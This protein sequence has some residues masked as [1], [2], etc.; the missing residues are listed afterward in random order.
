M[1]IGL[2]LLRLAEPFQAL[3]LGFLPAIPTSRLHLPAPL[4]STSITWLHRYYGRSDSC[5]GRLA[6]LPFLHRSPCLRSWAF[7]SFRLQSSLTFPGG[8]VWVLTTRAL[9]HDPAEFIFPL[10]LLFL[11]SLAS[12]GLRHWTEGSPRSRT[13][14]SSLALRTNLSPW[15]ALHLASLRRS[16]PQL[17]QAKPPSDGDSHPADSRSSQA[18][19]PPTALGGSLF[20]FHHL[21][22]E[23]HGTQSMGLLYFPHPPPL[24][25]PPSS[26]PFLIE[27][28]MFIRWC[29]PHAFFILPF[30]FFPQLPTLFPPGKGPFA[31][32]ARVSILHHCFCNFRL[33]ERRM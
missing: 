24:F 10:S 2:G 15:V 5:T 29:W 3:S 8:R 18:H 30:T 31:S 23:T 33:I 26:P 25:L 12:F 32:L 6:P 28:R 27:R 14:S 13:E 4:R 20:I 21:K 22:Q 16:Y 1:P 11:R 7:L 17:H 9:P 19:S